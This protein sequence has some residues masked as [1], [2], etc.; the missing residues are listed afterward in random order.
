VDRSGSVSQ[1]VSL[2]GQGLPSGAARAAGYAGAVVMVISAI[3]TGIVASLFGKAI[4]AAGL[5]PFSDD[6]HVLPPPPGLTPV[7]LLFATAVTLV[8][9]GIASLTGAAR[10]VSAV[11][12]LSSS[13]KGGA[14]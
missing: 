8:V 12:R 10:Q 9:I 2:R 7:A 1:L 4:V 3:A 11:S 14:Q 13:G 6:W 5:P